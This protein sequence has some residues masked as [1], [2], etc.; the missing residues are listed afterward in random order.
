MDENDVAFLDAETAAGEYAS[1]S[2]AVSAGVRLLR[3]RALER[4]YAEAFREW[5]DHP[6]AGLWEMAVADG[7][8]PTGRP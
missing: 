7:L 3:E 5:N 8:V 4:S 2:A 1:R 6:D